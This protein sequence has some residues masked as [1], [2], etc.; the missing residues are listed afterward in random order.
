MSALERIQRR[1]TDYI[2]SGKVTNYSEKAVTDFLLLATDDMKSRFNN[3]C[4]RDGRMYQL[5]DQAKEIA[6]PD[7]WA[8]FGKELQEF[9]NEKAK[10]Y[11]TWIGWKEPTF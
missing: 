10:Q 9:Q 3:Y 2:G 6:H 4:M 7:D 11:M 8:R 1:Q 5:L